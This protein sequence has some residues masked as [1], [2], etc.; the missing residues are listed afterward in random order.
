[1]R[2]MLATFLAWASLGA[3][4]A[5][6]PVTPAKSNHEAE[7]GAHTHGGSVE[8]AAIHAA[9]VAWK[10][11]C[12]HLVVK[13][14]PSRRISGATRVDVTFRKRPSDRPNPKYAGIVLNGDLHMGNDAVHAAVLGLWGTSGGAPAADLAWLAEYGGHCS[15]TEGPTQAGSDPECVGYRPTD[16]VQV[17]GRVGV[18]YWLRCRGRMRPSRSQHKWAAWVNSD[19]TIEKVQEGSCSDS[20]GTFRP[21]FP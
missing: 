1:M 9:A 21:P 3:F 12:D 18:R 7:S 19:H 6:P 14:R 15:I 13:N 8:A 17:D 10:T 4:A 16:A 11:T 2:G 5:V 20:D